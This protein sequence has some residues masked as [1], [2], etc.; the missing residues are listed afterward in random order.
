[1][2]ELTIIIPIYNEENRIEKSIKVL[3]KGFNFNGV[4]L[5]KVIFVDDGSND[6]I[7][8]ILR[9]AQLKRNLKTSYQLISYK[10]NRGR[11]HA[12]KI[13]AQFAKTDYVLYMDA[14]F[15][16]PLNNLN[17]FI[18]YMEDG[19]DVISGSK[20]MPKSIAK[21]PRGFV[22]NIIGYGHSLI[23]SILLGVFYWDF[24]GGFKIFSKK[25]IKEVFPMLRIDRWGFDME[26][27]FL[28]KKMGFK[29]KELPIVWSHVDKDSKVK[30]A[31]DIV[32]SLK[33]MFE[34]QVNWLTG[35]YHYHYHKFFPA[36]L[37]FHYL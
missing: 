26:V 30:L 3:K 14:D 35:K 4:E 28:A 18:P 12:V 15:S 27:L 21:L 13:G 7:K 29:T 20:K 22:R 31:R 6:E 36:R 24:Q 19:Y 32:K 34:I 16:I 5:K 23:A 33:D 25:Y 2:V 9:N 1:M 8:K 17:K 10:K 11:G 37:D